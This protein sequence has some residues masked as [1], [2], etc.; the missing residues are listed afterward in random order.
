MTSS[1]QPLRDASGAPSEAKQD[2]P[3]SMEE[4]GL[5][6]EG[7]GISTTSSKTQ[8]SGLIVV[9]ECSVCSSTLPS[10]HIEQCERC[11]ALFCRACAFLQYL[12]QCDLAKLDRVVPAW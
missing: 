4:G 10:S 3:W 9:E 6:T 1:A 12:H 8:S 11:A 5:R 7:D 2:T